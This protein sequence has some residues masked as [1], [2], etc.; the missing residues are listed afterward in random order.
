MAD[1][2]GSKN[3]GKLSSIDHAAV[4][5]V[6]SAASSE[7]LRLAP[8]SQRGRTNDVKDIELQTDHDKNGISS[9]TKHDNTALPHRY[10]RYKGS[11][12]FR[13]LWTGK[14]PFFGRASEADEGLSIDSK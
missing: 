4:S 11:P 13:R 10:I 12:I 3:D 8:S 2:Y 14:R 5:T 9:A 7:G 1:G 6:V